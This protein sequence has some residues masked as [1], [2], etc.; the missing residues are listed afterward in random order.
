MCMIMVFVMLKKLECEKDLRGKSI[1]FELV[2]LL[3]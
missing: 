3:V 2:L 1:K